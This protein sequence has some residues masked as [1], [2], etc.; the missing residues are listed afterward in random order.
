M[1]VKEK[2]FKNIYEEDFGR[3]FLE[4]LQAIS[5]DNNIRKIDL[6]LNTQKNCKYLIS[7]IMTLLPLG[8][9]N[10]DEHD[11]EEISFKKVNN[12]SNTLKVKL[13]GKSK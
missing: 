3:C 11:Y 10:D 2:I 1:I 8:I 5:K 4:Y 9:I 6:V 12:N 13:I 7:S